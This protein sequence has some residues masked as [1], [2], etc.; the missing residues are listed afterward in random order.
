MIKPN[1]YLTIFTLLPFLM[2]YRAP[3][4]HCNMAHFDPKIAKLKVALIWVKIE[5]LNE[6]ISCVCV[7]LL[8]HVMTYALQY[9]KLQIL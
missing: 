5:F 8:Y 3:I 1:K 2:E 9:I 7:H 4:P 6:L